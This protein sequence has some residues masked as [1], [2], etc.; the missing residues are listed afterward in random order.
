MRKSAD[1]QIKIALGGWITVSKAKW[2]EHERATGFRRKLPTD[3]PD[4]MRVCATGGF[5]GNSVG[6]RITPRFD[7]ALLR[8]TREGSCD[9]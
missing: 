1:Y 4:Y 3:H 5:Y 7:P 9:A 6:G 8:M 2:I